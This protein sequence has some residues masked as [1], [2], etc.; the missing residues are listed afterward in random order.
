[1][2]GI[3]E[4]DASA[5][6]LARCCISRGAGPEQLVGLLL[7][8]SPELITAIL[9][10]LA[11][12]AAYLPVDPDYP[13]ERLGFMLAD[14]RPVCVVTT[15]ERARLLPSTQPVV[16]LDD[17]GVVAELAGL[18]A[19]PV[20][21]ADRAVPLRPGHPAYVIYTSGSTG[22]PKGVVVT[23]A[24]I[25]ALSANQVTRFGVQPGSRVLQYASASF[26]ASLL[27]TLHGTAGWGG[28]G[29][30]GGE[31]AVVGGGVGAVGGAAG[32]DACDVAA[33]VAGGVAGRGVRR[34]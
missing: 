8:P 17:P 27:G 2:T 18:A 9:A 32:G 30:G 5:Y 13:A 24:G 23:H 14:A 10:V 4:L 6:R 1:M 29:G 20:T 12:G 33:G 22:T 31:A 19:G 21:D 16:A 25:A 34:G 3:A 15:S 28:F 7:D 11:A 26:D